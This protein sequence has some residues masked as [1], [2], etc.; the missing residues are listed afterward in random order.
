V[1][2]A[3]SLVV[4]VVSAVFQVAAAAGGVLLLSGCGSCQS[5]VRTV[6]MPGIAGAAFDGADID[7]QTHRIF[8]ANRTDQS[9]SAVD[10]GGQT[11]AGAGTVKLDA[12]PNGLALAP[13]R[14]TLYAALDSGG[15]A[16]I[17]TVSMRVTSTIPVDAT[18]ADL[19][20]YSARTNSLFVGVGA[21]VAVVDAA[22]GKVT[23]RIST[24]STVEQPRF[25]P[26]DGLVYATVPLTNSLVQMNPATGYITQSYTVAK[27][28]PSGLAINPS[29]QVAMLACGGS[30][31]LVNL[32]S[33]AQEVTR[34]VQGGDVVTY[35]AAA[36]TF[37]IASPHGPTD[38]VVGAFGGD[39][40]FIAS[41]SS[42]PN[43]HAAV[44]DEGHGV[45]FAPAPAG[46]MSF[47]PAQCAPPPDW[48]RFT[49]GLSLFAVPASAFVLFLFLYARRLRREPV[50]RSRPSDRELRAQD[51]A[52]EIERMRELEDGILGPEG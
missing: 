15:V 44:Y 34:A 41:V 46:L 30:V 21:A 5:T 47:A 32:T 39:G 26:A 6:T 28:H 22:T 20:D 42:T 14:H 51:L 7:Q 37:V 13:G 36:D 48:L 29:R 45:V 31:A 25:D 11:P 8:L 10:V 50:E 23:R 38:S 52:L 49:G 1:K 24:A 12:S 4:A 40:H 19:I 16:V 9:I 18:S 3:G 17:D 33:G 2:R 27:C 35:D 43:V